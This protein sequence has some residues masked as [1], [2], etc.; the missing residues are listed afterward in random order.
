MAEIVLVTGG[1]R[2]GKSDYALNRAE[3]IGGSKCFVATCEVLDQ[4]MAERVRK[5]RQD[6]D[7]SLWTT[8]EETLAVASVIGRN[9]YD[10]YL[11]DCLTLWISNVMAEFE[12]RGAVCGEVAIAE[13]ITSIIDNALELSGTVVVVS[14]EVG[15]GIVPDNALARKYRDLV[16]LCNRMVAAAAAEVVLVSCG[17]PLHIKKKG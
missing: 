3:Q 8:V 16:G 10:V 11:I 15:M 9:K 2:S 13:E 1:A 14:N 12:Q 17:I 7:G 6:R 4:E 5:H